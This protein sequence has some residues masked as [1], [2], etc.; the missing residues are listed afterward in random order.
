MCNK[1]FLLYCYVLIGSIFGKEII[2]EEICNNEDFFPQCE[3]G[4]T[5]EIVNANYGRMQI[6]RCVQA[7]LG[8]NPN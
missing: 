4:K 3:D 2:T 5:L 8:K 1:L 7:D 6:G